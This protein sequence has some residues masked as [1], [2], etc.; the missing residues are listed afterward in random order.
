MKL[1]PLTQGQFAKVN[2]CDFAWLSKW[3][4]Y[5][6]WNPHTQSFYAVRTP[7]EDGKHRNILMARMILGLEHNDGKLADHWNGD[8]L[9]NQRHNLRA[10]D[11]RG[12]CQNTKHHRKGKLV[13]AT[14][15]KRRHKWESKIYVAGKRKFLGYFDTELK[16]HNTYVIAAQNLEGVQLAVV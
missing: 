13:G 14:F 16:A 3:K 5:A 9:D 15:D 10:T 4:W 7:Y 2:D 6:Q 12:N 8:S 1:I 11:T